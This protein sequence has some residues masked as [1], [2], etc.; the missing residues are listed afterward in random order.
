MNNFLFR[1]DDGPGVGSGHLMRCL[2]LAEEICQSGRKVHLLAMRPSVLHHRWRVIGADVMI[3]DCRI[4]SEED[5]AVTLQAASLLEADWVVVD[6]YGFTVDWLDA[7]G[8]ER[9]TLCLDDVGVRDPSVALVLNH[10]PGAEQRYAGSYR[11]CKQALLGSDW[12]LLRSEFKNQVRCPENG[13]ILVCLGGEDPDNRTLHVIQALVAG[14]GVDFGVDVVCNNAQFAGIAEMAE[15]AVSAGW[16]FQVHP[17][18]LALAP[19]MGRAHVMICGGGVT[20]VEALSMGLNV[21]AIVLAENQA[22]G[23]AYL[24]NTGALDVVQVTG[25]WAEYAAGAALK[26][27][28]RSASTNDQKML[29]RFDGGGAGR[30]LVRM[31]AR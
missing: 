25:D 30:V 11:R 10:N 13:Q 3:R 27:V 9:N 21:V 24:A 7:V 4:G 17:G 20:A 6:G 18:P 19:L 15:L 23:I 16:R 2:A 8:G 22:E 26:Y 1:V 28:A 29:F 12:F 31:I 5:L 14:R